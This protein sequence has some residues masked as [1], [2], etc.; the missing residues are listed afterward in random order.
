MK[1]PT[2]TVGIRVDLERFSSIELELSFTRL[3]HGSVINQ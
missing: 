3:K 2:D 1:R